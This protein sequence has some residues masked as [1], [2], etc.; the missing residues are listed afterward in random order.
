MFSKQIDLSIGQLE[1]EAELSSRSNIR[2]EEVFYDLIY[3]E[4]IFTIYNSCTIQKNSDHV[5]QC[6]THVFWMVPFPSLSLVS[7]LFL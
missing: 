2:L 6:Q 5:L 7:I 3:I 1:A 4:K